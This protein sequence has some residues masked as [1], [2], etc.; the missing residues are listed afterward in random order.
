MLKV[1][2]PIIV[3]LCILLIK[4]IPYIGG[5]LSIAL[6]I[7]GILALIMGGIYNPLTWLMAWIDGVDRLMWVIL[8]GA[9]GCIYADM[10]GELGAM[11]TIVNSL[12][13]KFGHSPKGLVITVFMALMI[14]GSL[15]GD[16]MAA[17]TVV[18]LLT[19]GAL[20][21]LGLPGERVAAVLII[22]ASLG[23]PMPPIAQS[24]FLSAALLGLE[25]P[26]PV[27]AI[28][29]F[30]I[31]ITAIIALLVMLKMFIKKDMTMNEDLIPKEKASQILKARWYTLI[32][33]TI[34]AIVVFARSLPAPYKIDIIPLILNKIT[35]GGQGFLQWL[36]TIKILKGFSNVI[37]LAM[38]TCIIIS[39]IFFKEVRNN[40]PKI[41]KGGLKKVRPNAQVQFSAGLF[42]GGFYAAG[43][44][45]AI[46]AF[47]QGLN[48]NLLKFGGAGAIT[49]IGMV[50]G[51]QSTAQNVIVSFWGPALVE[52]GLTPVNAAMAASHFAIAGQALPPV[53]LMALAVCGIVG[54]MLGV[55]IDPIKTM[56]YSIPFCIVLMV[57]G[58]IFMYI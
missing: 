3:L 26:D 51:S 8:L 17:S 16:S 15:L 22:G 5:N 35:V 30:T 28:S 32:P 46:K 1:I 54:G 38:I 37:V 41:F 4:K 53:D 10:Q 58:T 23:S 55:K 47:V 12:R 18:G 45:E 40:L 27:T 44:I 25:T 9:C 6:I 50:T 20:A 48:T 21:E 56:M 36:G 7:A 33:L 31:G 2:I 52:T 49:L 19:V 13:A 42:L 11:E 39:T 29:Y 43:Q 24:L 34:L 57:I 14:A